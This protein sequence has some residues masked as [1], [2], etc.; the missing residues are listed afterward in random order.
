MPHLH[1]HLHPHLDPHHLERHR[2]Q[3]LRR[4][5]G[6][7]IHVRGQWIRWVSPPPCRLP[8]P[9]LHM[10]TPPRIPPFHLV[11]PRQPQAALAR[12][13]PV[14]RGRGGMKRGEPLRVGCD[15]TT[16]RTH[17]PT[18]RLARPSAA[19]RQTVRCCWRSTRVM[20]PRVRGRDRWGWCGRGG[21][22]WVVVRADVPPKPS[23][24]PSSP[25][26]ARVHAERGG[27][28]HAQGPSLVLGPAI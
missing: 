24:T 10:T 13:L 12:R 6:R 2:P 14:L 28:T 4:P 23:T 22:G 15:R 21:G 9:T 27:A 26:R 25:W 16:P 7:E 17:P 11:L 20:R 3:R 8:L 1:P 5:V 19:A 18:P